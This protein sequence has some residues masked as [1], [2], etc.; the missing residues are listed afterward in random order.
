MGKTLGDDYRLFV[1]DVSGD[2]FSQPAGQGNLT[3]SRS[4]SPIDQTTKDNGRWGT[5]APGPKSLSA[6]QAFIPDLPDPAFAR[7]KALDASGDA[8]VYQVRYKPFAAD[9]V[10]FECLLYTSFG[11]T[12]LEQR[13]N[14][15]TSATLT[16]AEAPT[17]DNL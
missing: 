11:D 10:E 16:A 13:G 6:T 14:R 3:I 5:S 8:A 12:G 7:M 1:K 15:N 9:D 17:V 2:G 4:S